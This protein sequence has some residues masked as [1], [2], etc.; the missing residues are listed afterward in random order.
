MKKKDI[1]FWGKVEGGRLKLNTPDRFKK[2]LAR[3]KGIISLTI[4]ERKKI[5]T[6]P[7]NSLYWLWITII[8]D[9]LG[10]DKEE[11]HATFKAMY[12]SE[13]KYITNKQTGEVIETHIVRSTT[14]MNVVEFVEYMEK[15]ERFAAE[16]GIILPQPNDG[17]FEGVS[18]DFAQ[19][20]ENTRDL[21]KKQAEATEND[22]D[23]NI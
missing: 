1:T 13:I 18:R 14:V 11:M 20:G 21:P 15:I 10:Y 4:K 9:E 19:K 16:M 17:V 2:H 23:F 6:I 8:G 3:L 5:R 7:Q 22:S 12:N